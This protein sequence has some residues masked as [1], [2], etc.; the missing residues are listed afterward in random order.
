MTAEILTIGDEILRGEILDSNKAFLSE[1]LLTLDLETRF[2]GSVRD[3]PEDMAAAFRCAAHR[4]D[5][6]LVSGGLGPT[7][8]D[9][10]TE[11][12]AKTF[13]RKLV[14]D[15][16]CL[17]EIRAFF[18]R[19]GRQMPENNAKQACFPEGADVLPNPIGTAPGCLLEEEGTLFFCLPGVPRELARMTDE[20]VLPR[21]A[22]HLGKRE[23]VVRSTLL[24]TFGLGE[25]NLDERLRDVATEPGVSLG[26]RTAFPDN[27]LRPVVRAKT[28]EEAE[29][30]LAR[31]C[32]TVRERLGPLVY[33]VGETESLETVTLQLLRDQRRSLAVAESCTG[34]L[35]AQRI[36]S[37][38]GASE[39]FRGGVVAYSDEA[40]RELLGVDAKLLEEHG[41]VSDPTAR[42]MAHGA[43]AR[44]GAD[45]ALATTGIAGPSG[46]TP[47]KP[48]GLI[49]LALAQESGIWAEEF[50]FPFDRERHR[51]LT[52]Q[53]ALDW[54]RRTLLALEPTPLRWGRRSR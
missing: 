4:S 35:L 13:G 9:L 40:K 54:I 29:T 24:R 27:L 8:D 7:R 43:R 11:V 50:H 32:A 16:A 52:S 34:G 42:A 38:P 30:K 33:G 45:L 15:E 49:H 12:L 31:V 23:V 36:T 22:Q 19:F 26:F 48:V 18:R 20:Q 5:V 41:A 51:T 2:H 14:L 53:I 46:G 44:F 25:S 47:T 39:V 21:L 1:R 6:V 37:V 28:S 3:E 17:E 10:T